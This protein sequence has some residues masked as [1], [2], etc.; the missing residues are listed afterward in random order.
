MRWNE[1]PERKEPPDFDN[2][3]AVLRRKIPHR[4][5]LFEFY[6]N[7][8]IYSRVVPGPAPTDSEAW[9]RRFIMTFHRLGY[10][11]TTILLPGFQFSDP[12]LRETKETFSMNEG[13]V[14]RSQKE[15]DAFDWPDPEDPGLYRGLKIQAENLHNG[16]DYAVIIDLGI[17]IV[18]RAQFVRGFTEFLMDMITHVEFAKALLNKLGQIWIRIA[19]NAL[20][21]V[22]HLVDIV[23]WGD[24][25]GM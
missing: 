15:F 8:R 10:D 5:T 18:T 21:E 16:T 3:L 7:E 12:D 1:I 14:I 9:L 6:F 17:G 25:Y 23:F 20:Q 19:R 2:L 13:A 11:F 4:P 22:G 24:D